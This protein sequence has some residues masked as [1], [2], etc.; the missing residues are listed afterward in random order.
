MLLAYEGDQ[1]YIFISYSHRNSRYIHGVIEYLQSCGYRVWYD[2][3]IE[4]GSEW[5]EYIASHLEKCSCVLTFMSHAFV[6]SDNCKRELHFAQDL[7]KP[8][9]NVYIE[10]VQL[11]AGL[12]MQLGLCQ[13]MYRDNFRTEGEFLQSLARA[14][15][16][17]GCKEGT[18][19]Q[20]VMA[21][22]RAENFAPE[23]NVW[24]GPSIPVD[25]TDDALLDE[26]DEELKSCEN[27]ID[28]LLEETEEEIP[29][30]S[31]GLKALGWFMILLELSYCVI[32]TEALD[33]L[34]A[35][36][37]GVWKL[38]LLSAVPHIV[39]AVVNSILSKIMVGKTHPSNRDNFTVPL[40]FL[41]VVT[42]VVVA[43]VGI[44]KIH[45][46]LSSFVKFLVALGLNVIPTAVAF[47]IYAVALVD[48]KEE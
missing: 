44:S 8:L 18:V 11:S 21:P 7:K 13:A 46:D 48:D 6:E 23:E 35:K 34:T 41:S 32:G 30:M 38:I 27:E 42:A 14:K 15:I 5:P 17:E 9:L 40:F 36:D 47:V 43:V 37:M 25:D 16:L 22:V 45:Y 4:A 10:D 1:P 3:G 39:I 24:N 26:Y 19:Q 31:G 2:G 12:R 29:P 20:V 33:F 28:D